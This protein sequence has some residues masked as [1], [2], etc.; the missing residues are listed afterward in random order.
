MTEVSSG[1]IKI[2]CFVEQWGKMGIKA[3]H[4]K[5]GFDEQ[6]LAKCGSDVNQ[7]DALLI[8]YS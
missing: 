7:D 6:Y 8:I 5:N 4:R 2:P 1:T 3:K